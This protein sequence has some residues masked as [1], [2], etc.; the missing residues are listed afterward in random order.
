MLARPF[1]GFPNK[2]FIYNEQ[3]DNLPFIIDTNDKV[4]IG[5]TSPQAKLDVYGNIHVDAY[6]GLQ[7]YSSGS[8]IWGLQRFD[9][10]YDKLSIM[11]NDSISLYNNVSNP[12]SPG[13]P[14]M[15]LK[16]GNV[17]IGTTNPNA[18]L[19][20]SGT[21]SAT[22]FVGDGSGLSG[23][24]AGDNITSGTSK[25]TVN[26]ATSTISF[27]TNGTVSNYINSSGLLITTGIGVGV[28]NPQGYLHIADD[29]VSKALLLAPSTYTY[30]GYNRGFSNMAR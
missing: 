4:G 17:G 18:N 3:T 24:A 16:S 1:M 13:S 6:G 7:G 20:V 12:G 26:S 15:T 21:V 9:D 25:V 2:F 29:N 14:A 19:E 10:G 28:A 11:S 30:G 5:T 8:F 27:T 22:H 23:V